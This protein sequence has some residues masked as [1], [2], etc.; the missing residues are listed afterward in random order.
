MRVYAV[1]LVDIEGFGIDEI[2]RSYETAEQWR[3]AKQ[4]VHESQV[5]AQQRADAEK[6]QYPPDEYEEDLDGHYTV[7]AWDVLDEL[8]ELPATTGGES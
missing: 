2:F 5:R 4:I 7:E 1:L 6:G 3:E 8:P